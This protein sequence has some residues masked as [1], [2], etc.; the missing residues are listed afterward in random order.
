VAGRS[1]AR[2]DRYD[3]PPARLLRALCVGYNEL[4]ADLLWIK[5]ISYFADHLLGD[6]DFRHLERHL[7]SLLALDDRFVEVYRYGATMLVTRTLSASNDE[8]LS[9]IA[10]LKKAHR[11]WPDDWRFPLSIGTY[12]LELKPKNELQRRRFRREGADFVFRASVIGADIP[13]LP[14]LAAKIYT[15]QG[16]RELAIHHLKE[17]YL[18]IQDPDTRHQI[19]SKLR[20]LVAAKEHEELRAHREAFETAL[21]TSRVRFVPP[22]LFILIDLPPLEPF[23]LALHG[24]VSKLP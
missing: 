12:Y 20:T 17:L 7:S 16:A 24:P 8:I 5:T 21:R 4:G 23:S 22:D 18:T 3:L 11:L 13:W 15:E 14:A 1:L 6:R 9:A 10:L 19:A 2:A